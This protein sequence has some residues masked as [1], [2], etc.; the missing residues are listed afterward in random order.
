MIFDDHT[1]LA[2][3]TDFNL[4]IGADDIKVISPMRMNKIL[5]RE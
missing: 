2:K 1:A 4:I 5:N 3:Y